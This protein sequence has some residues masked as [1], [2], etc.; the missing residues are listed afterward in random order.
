MKNQQNKTEMDNVEQLIGK[1]MQVGV[2]LAAA[3]ML[4][5]VLMLLLIRCS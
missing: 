5:G 1:V 3:V 2:L 4:I